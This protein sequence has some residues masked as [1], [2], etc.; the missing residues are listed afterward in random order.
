[1]SSAVS[2]NHFTLAFPFRSPTD[3]DVLPPKLT[4]LMPDM[5]R[6]EDAIGTVHYS[7]FTVLSEKTLLFLGDFDGEFGQLMLDLAT[8][9]GLGVRHHLRA[10][11]RIR[12]PRRSPITRK[13]SSNGRRN[14]SCTQPS[15][16]PP[17]PV[18]L[19]GRSRPWPPP[20]T[21]RAPASRTSS[22]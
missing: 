4:S 13:H 14:T 21:S 1:M 6:A 5:F 11:G 12:P 22:S 19:P 9:A 16:T 10:R 20:R 15:S 18:P 8:Q 2:Q 3:A 7:R 17:T